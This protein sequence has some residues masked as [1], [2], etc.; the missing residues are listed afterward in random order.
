[1]TSVMERTTA[2][3]RLTDYDRSAMLSVLK[4]VIERNRTEVKHRFPL[5]REDFL[6]FYW[7][8]VELQE[9]GIHALVEEVERRMTWGT[10]DSFCRMDNEV[11][12]E[13]ANITTPIGRFCGKINLYFPGFERVGSTRVRITDAHPLYN[14][15]VTWYNEAAV[16]HD[17]VESAMY[18]A[19]NL[20][21]R[22]STT[23]QVLRLLPE[24]AH[25][26]Y[27]QDYLKRLIAQTKRRSAL[28]WALSSEQAIEELAIINQMYSQ[29][30]IL[31]KQEDCGYIG[32]PKG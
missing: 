18:I 24:L 5:E 7:Q 13:L 16:T 28:P 26:L 21:H 20:C 12:F 17:K 15:L 1:M 3:K 10:S 22:V 4:D 27:T 11:F 2:S 19:E 23:G 8:S 31:G 14:K 9:P 25:D 29:G 6:E 32:L 30:L